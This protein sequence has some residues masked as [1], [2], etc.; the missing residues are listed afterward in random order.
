MTGVLIRREKFGHRHAQRG[1]CPIKTLTWKEKT[2]WWQKQRLE[3]CSCKPGNTKDW[4]PRPD[5]RKKQGLNSTQTLERAWPWW[6]LDISLLA[7]SVVLSLAALCIGS[8]RKLMQRAKCPI[9]STPPCL[10]STY[11]RRKRT[12]IHLGRHNSSDT[13]WGA[14]PDAERDAH[15]PFPEYSPNTWSGITMRVT[16]QAKDGLAVT[17]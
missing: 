17:A 13:V 11:Q 1:E 7:I 16:R 6:H 4:Q 3:C 10:F 8:P 5:T 12:S 15:Q 2:M 9:S 14:C